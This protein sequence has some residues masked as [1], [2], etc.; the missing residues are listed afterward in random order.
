MCGT[1]KMSK[2]Y[3]VVRVD[4]TTAVMKS[5]MARGNISTAIEYVQTCG[6]GLLSART[7][8]YS[9]TAM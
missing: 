8:R 5:E 9:S 3:G 1:S 7:G 2:K 4:G 6:E